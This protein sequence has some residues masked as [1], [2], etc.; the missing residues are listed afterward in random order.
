MFEY[1]QKSTVVESLNEG[2]AAR[3]LIFVRNIPAWVGGDLVAVE[4]HLRCRGKSR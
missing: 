1:S 4:H 2:F 3:N